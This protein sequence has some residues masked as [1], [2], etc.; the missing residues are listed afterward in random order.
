MGKRAWRQLAPYS[1]IP[2]LAIT[3]LFVRW[4]DLDR[5]TLLQRELLLV[6]GY[7]IAIKDT[8]DKSIPNRMILALLVCWLFTIFPQLVVDIEIGLDRLTN[9]AIGFLI[10]GGLF[11][12]VYLIS[13]NGLGGGDVKL[14]AVV[15]LYLGMSG[16]LPA[17]LYGSILAAI[18]GL[19][20][21][22]LKKIGRKDTIPLVPFLY[23]GILIAIFFF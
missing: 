20:L 5:F 10:G 4:P 8:R 21:I 2:L 13:K 14:M 9:A 3:L 7:L 19:V 16:V 6:I 18:F 23:I 22:L 15:G 17:M 12:L 1:G 11:L